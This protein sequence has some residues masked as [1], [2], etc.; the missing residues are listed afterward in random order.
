MT[1][2][3]ESIGFATALL[4]LGCAPH[5]AQAQASANDTVP[6][7]APDTR[8]AWFDDDSSWAGDGTF[9][10]LKHVISLTFHDS[11][12]QAQRQ[13][14]VTLVEG[15]VVGG[16]RFT[17]NREGLYAVHLADSVNAGRRDA[18][19]EQLRALPQVKAAMPVRG[20][21]SAARRARGACR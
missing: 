2:A 15:H 17:P 9:C 11:A 4:C 8:P 5:R 18:L 12:S 10:T 20:I 19:L 13:A 21:A 3:I 14:A 1:R 16:W 7:V 6:L